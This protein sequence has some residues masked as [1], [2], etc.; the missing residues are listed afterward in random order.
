MARGQVTIEFVLVLV[1]MLTVLATLSIPLA[2][3]VAEETI[4]TG[5]A[6][7]LGSS[8]QR[9]VQAAEEVSYSGCGSYKNIS[10]YIE[11][12]ALAGATMY[13]DDDE[14]WSEYTNMTADQVT[15]KKL[16][17]AKYT[18]M[19]AYCGAY[20]HTYVVKVEKDCNSQRPAPEQLGNGKTLFGN[21]AY[22]GYRCTL[23]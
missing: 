19:T 17:Y 12:D 21:N 5:I 11:P 10:I 22:I 15:T 16:T 18:K 4:D 3:D 14:V 6:L 23:T 9:L 13:I 7:A 1:V 2:K 20:G 8:A